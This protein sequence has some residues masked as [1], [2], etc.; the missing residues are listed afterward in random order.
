MDRANPSFLVDE[1]LLANPLTPPAELPSR[2]ERLPFTIRAE[3]GDRGRDAVVL[4]AQSRLD[5]EPVGTM[6]IQSNAHGPLPL[7]ASVALPPEMAGCRLAEATQLAVR[8]GLMGRA[9]KVALCK[10][11]LTYCRAAAIDWV[12][13][14]ARAPLDRDFEAM[15]FDDVH[16]AHETFPMTHLDGQAH[17]LMAKRVASA[18][19]RWA[20]VQH[21]LYGCMFETQHPDID[22]TPRPS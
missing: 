2:S 8:D 5:H 6:R 16:G 15:L 18:Q 10:A 9:V 12:V 3:A 7:E 21:P 17:R 20:E 11:L 1:S 13:I 14:A 19:R 4:L 22:V